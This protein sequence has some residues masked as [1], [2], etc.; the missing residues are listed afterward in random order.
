[1]SL[2]TIPKPGKGRSVKIGAK[3]RCTFKVTGKDT[4]GPF[5]LFEYA[6]AAGAEG[7]RLHLH[8]RLPKMFYVAEGEMELLLEQRR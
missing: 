3:T 5:G 1:M 8:K 7:A 6:M 2:P 4:Q